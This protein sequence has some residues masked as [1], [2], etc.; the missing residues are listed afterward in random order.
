MTINMKNVMAIL[1]RFGARLAVSR[2]ASVDR[3]PN[4]DRTSP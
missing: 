2:Q 1:P 4:T 3:I